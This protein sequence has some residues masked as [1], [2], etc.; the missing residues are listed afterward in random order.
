VKKR[1]NNDLL[2]VQN[3][4]SEADYRSR[5]GDTVEVLVEGPSKHDDGTSSVHQ[6][7]G[8]TMTDHIVVFDGPMRLAGQMVKVAVYDASPFT[9]FGEVITTELVGMAEKCCDHQGI[10]PV[11]NALIGLPI[12]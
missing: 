12:L 11:T 7:T 9:L 4:V 8:R 1:R 5:I 10:A 6:L 2:C 3:D